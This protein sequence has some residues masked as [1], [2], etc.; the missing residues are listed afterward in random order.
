MTLKSTPADNYSYLQGLADRKDIQTA[1]AARSPAVS[2]GHGESTAADRY[3]YVTASFRDVCRL[4]DGRLADLTERHNL[5]L[6]PT[7]PRAMVTAP[8][9]KVDLMAQLDTENVAG[10]VFAIEQGWP[11]RNLASATR[12]VLDR[13]LRV[14]YYWPNETSVE[15]IDDE[16]LSSLRKHW[17]VA[18]A[19][20]CYTI[21]KP[22]CDRFAKVCGVVG[23]AAQPLVRLGQKVAAK[24][25]NVLRP[26]YHYV[27]HRLVSNKAGMLAPKS[28][29]EHLQTIQ[30]IA[31]T[32][33]PIPFS[34]AIKSATID[35]KIPGTGV[36]LRLDFWAGGHPGGSYGHTCYVAKELSRVSEDMVCFMAN[37]YA[38]LDQM[39]LTQVVLDPPADHGTEE[40]LILGTQYY[41]SILKPALAAMKPA[42]IY[43]RLCLGNSAGAKLAQELRIPYIVEYNGSEI[44]M[45][46]SFEGRGYEYEEL[47]LEAENASFRQAT[48][49]SVVSTAVRDEL[50]ARGV[51][52]GK[53][54]VNPNGV[55]PEDYAPAGQTE[56][57]ALRKELG[58]TEKETVIGFVGT[59][60][61]W[62]GIEVLAESLPEICGQLPDARFLLIG[63]GA[64]KNLVDDVV[65]KRGLAQRVVM[66][67]RKPH[68]EACRLLKACDLYVSP[69][70]SHMVGSRF[71]GSPTKVFEY[72]GLGGGIVA[73]DLEQLGEVLSPALKVADFRSTTLQ[74][75][76]ERSVLVAP[77][78]VPE[79]VAAVVAL[80]KRPEIAKRLGENARQAVLDEYCWERH[81]AKLWT[82]QQVRPNND[83][84][85]KLVTKEGKNPFSGAQVDFITTGD[86]YKDEVQNQWNNNPC[87]S[88]YVKEAK[89][90]TLEW[91]I[92]VERYRYEEYAPW[93]FEVMEFGRHANEKVLEIGGGIGTDLAQFA[94]HGSKTTD[95]DLSGTHLALAKENFA[96]RGLPGEF[97]HHDAETLPFPD[98]TFDV[99]YSNGVI[100]HTPNTKQLVGEIRRVLKPGGKCIIMV[101]AENSLHYWGAQVWQQGLS[102][103]MLAEHSIGWVMSTGVELNDNDARPLVKVYTAPRLRKMFHEFENVS[104]VKRQ[105]TDPEYPKWMRRVM[106]LETAG[107]LMGWNLILKGTKGKG[108]A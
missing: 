102:K 81:V 36:Y 30:A 61:G 51:E 38:L 71:F 103:G 4:F 40:A 28:A 6:E 47:Y 85:G 89:P 57:A 94:K 39:G 14:Y 46:R 31:R 18:R 86:S 25:K 21:L 50:I 24:A 16:R 15:V 62:H 7:S 108:D 92:E 54:L 1:D 65:A 99:V 19:F 100:H 73:S 37:H 69:H 101:Y 29:H 90:H 56:K 88:Q 93:M 23:Q 12:K 11:S 59:F 13:G 53:I 9:G 96:L 64:H 3:L 72:M 80:G 104:I 83:A 34:K 87:G 33:R 2:T 98:N 22:H 66:V 55:D 67:G 5:R 52:P 82:H 79:F 42:F 106:S 60:G 41:S 49:I 75:T 43:E 26:Y 105:L 95:C 8:S 76:N 77:G 32:A 91:F 107:K 78:N 17:W 68:A 70:S 84:V 20:Q 27:K 74:V 97:V 35:S 48:L 58:F 10:V 63:D 45:R 44:I